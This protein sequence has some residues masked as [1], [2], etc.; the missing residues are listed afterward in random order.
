VEK[1]PLKETLF[2]AMVASAPKIIEAMLQK[3][4]VVAMLDHGNYK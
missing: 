1:I 2:W 4:I 3:K